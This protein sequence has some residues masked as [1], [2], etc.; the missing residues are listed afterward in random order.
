MANHTMIQKRSLDTHRLNKIALWMMIG[1]LALAVLLYF[2]IAAAA[3]VQLSAPKRNFDPANNP[4]Q[5]TL[6]FEEVTYPSRGD[7]TK[8]AA[9]FIPATDASKAIILVH[10]RDDSRT[11]AFKG[12]FPGFAASLVK[13]GYSVLMIDLR[14]HGQSGDG[15]FTFGIKERWDVQ[16]GMD[17][18]VSQ[19]L[20]PGSIAVFGYSLGAG[21]VL[22]AAADEPGIGA[23]VTEAAFA[24]IKPVIQQ[25]WA[26]ESGL[27]NLLLSPSL[28]MIKL[29][30]GYD[31][32][33]SRPLDEVSRI[34]PRPVLLIH[35]TTDE[36]IAYANM[37]KLAVKM[38]Q[39]KTW[40]IEGCPHGFAYNF[41]PA[42]YTQHVVQF[43]DANLGG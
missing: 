35:C 26:K 27:P 11:K 30:Y 38:P 13:A 1:L 33:A 18:L 39:A 32:A 20:A 9:W 14:G 12:K 8:I 19:G 41:D 40:T 37:Q 22:G 4:G 28:S 43:L 29:L 42:A 5:Y 17:W 16:G 2:G 23:V 31:V 36:M 15:R 34:S 10:G 3:A 24:D 25:N 6:K 21:S 7:Q